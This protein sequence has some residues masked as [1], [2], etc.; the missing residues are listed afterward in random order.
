MGFDHRTDATSGVADQ[1]VRGSELQL[2]TGY[3]CVNILSPVC[4]C[5][6][7]ACAF[8]LIPDGVLI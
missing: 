6:A 1:W 3:I 5:V 7:E 4:V 2:L 8:H